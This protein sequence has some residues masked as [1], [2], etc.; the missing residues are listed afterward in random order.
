M[1]IAN[2]LAKTGEYELILRQRKIKITVIIDIKEIDNTLFEM[3]TTS[4]LHPAVAGFGAQF[5]LN[6]FAHKKCSTTVN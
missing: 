6:G 2:P 3:E 1:Q 5:L 4:R